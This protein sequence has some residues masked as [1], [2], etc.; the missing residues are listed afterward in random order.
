MIKSKLEEALL[1]VNWIPKDLVA[2]VEVIRQR[3]ICTLKEPEIGRCPE[4]GIMSNSIKNRYPRT[5]LGIGILGHRFEVKLMR[6]HFRCRSEGCERKTFAPKLGIADGK[7]PYLPALK[8]YLAQEH[9][10]KKHNNH[11]MVRDVKGRY[12]IQISE[13]TLRRLQGQR[14]TG[15]SEAKPEVIGLDELYPKGRHGVCL[16]MHDL[17]SGIL[18]GL[19]KGV[20]RI[21]LKDL[22][23]QLKKQG[24]NLDKVRYVYRDLYPHWDKV[25]KEE[26]GQRVTVMADPFHVIKH[27]QKLLYQG[28]YAP[29]RKQLKEQGKK[30][31]S[32]ALFYARWAFK[33][34]SEKLTGKQKLRLMPLLSEYRVIDK[35]WILKEKL[36][37]VYQV[38]NRAEA[39]KK[40]VWSLVYAREN[41]FKEVYKSLK[42]NQ[43]AILNIYEECN[44]PRRSI[45]HHPEERISQIRRVERRRGCFRKLENLT[46]N[47]QIEHEMSQEVN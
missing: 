24:M 41:N 22:F 17:M 9:F 19:I 13:G 26:L 20:R 6:V 43:L 3:I 34:G 14:G 40:L 42:R 46:R 29:L 32:T 33:R 1:Q 15:L 4:C 44:G 36:R 30:E 35:A 27:I 21:D 47:I 28:Y 23:G 39:R 2:G 8:E 31:A 7:S 5:L 16:S 10:V 11:E 37:E 45:R 12:R 25:I 18:L 38:P